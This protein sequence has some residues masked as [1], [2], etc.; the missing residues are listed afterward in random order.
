MPETQHERR[1]LRYDF[2]AVEVHNLSTELA[3]KNLEQQ[4]VEN[5]AKSVASQYTSNLKVI[6]SEVNKLSRMVSDGFEYR[7]VEVDIDYHKPEAGKKTVTRKDNGMVS[8]EKMDPYE[9]NLF[10]QEPDK[11]DDDI[12]DAD[13]VEGPKLLGDGSENTIEDDDTDNDDD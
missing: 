4:E 5:E 12:Q 6:K 8:V 2:T 1:K 10:T 13:V 7:D 9:W 11:N 3:R